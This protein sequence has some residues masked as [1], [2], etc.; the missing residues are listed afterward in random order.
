MILH[1]PKG[2]LVVAIYFT[3]FKRWIQFGGGRNTQFLYA[4]AGPVS[5]AWRRATVAAS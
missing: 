3:P 2:K 4:W 5:L 1:T